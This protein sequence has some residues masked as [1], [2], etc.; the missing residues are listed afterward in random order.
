[1]LRVAE[2]VHSNIGERVWL[3]WLVDEFKEQ[4]FKI[5]EVDRCIAG[6]REDAENDKL[7]V[8]MLV[9]DISMHEC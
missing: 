6:S 4:N 9:L 3:T 8:G 7:P 5:A 2:I 1:V